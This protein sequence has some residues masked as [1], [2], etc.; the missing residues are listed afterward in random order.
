MYKSFQIA[1]R[2]YRLDVRKAAAAAVGMVGW[3]AG[4]TVFF[5]AIFGRIAGVL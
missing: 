4:W 5:A 2:R 1:G 3:L